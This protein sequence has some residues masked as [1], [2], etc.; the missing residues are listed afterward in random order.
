MSLTNGIINVVASSTIANPAAILSK[1]SNSLTMINAA[2]QASLTPST[3]SIVVSGNLSS[4]LESSCLSTSIPIETVLRGV[5][6]SWL[7]CRTMDLFASKSRLHSLI[8]SFA[9]T[10]SNSNSFFAATWPDFSWTNRHI[11]SL[12]C[13][14][15]RNIIQ[16][17]GVLTAIQW[18]GSAPT[19]DRHLLTIMICTTQ[20]SCNAVWLQPFMNTCIITSSMAEKSSWSTG[21]IWSANIGLHSWSGQGWLVLRHG[22]TCTLASKSRLDDD[23][24][25][26]NAASS[27]IF[28]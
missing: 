19:S 1:A 24:A 17:N 16:I 23:D 11:I 7:M 27:R 15:D 4:D 26:S 18:N 20:E 12:S 10:S 3:N 2:P 25:N 14:Y 9:I 6:I 22:P 13:S 28:P 21:I 5:L 8:F